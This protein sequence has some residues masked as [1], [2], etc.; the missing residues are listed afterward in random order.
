M[1]AGNVFV[2]GF[3]IASSFA[4]VI[5]ILVSVI[6]RATTSLRVV[7]VS[8]VRNVTTAP[9]LLVVD[10]LGTGRCGC[11]TFSMTITTRPAAVL[12][13]RAGHFGNHGRCTVSAISMAVSDHILRGQLL[14]RV[15]RWSGIIDFG[16]DRWTSAG[17]LLDWSRRRCSLAARLGD[18]IEFGV[19]RKGQRWNS[20]DHDDCGIDHGLGWGLFVLLITVVGPWCRLLA[21][22]LQ[23]LIARLMH[24]DQLMM[25]WGL[26]ELVDAVVLLMRMESIVIMPAG[27]AFLIFGGYRFLGL[28][29]LI[30]RLS[31]TLGAAAQVFRHPMP[32]LAGSM[33]AIVAL[34]RRELAVLV[35]AFVIALAGE[36][37]F[38]RFVTSLASTEVAGHLPMSASIDRID[39]D[40]MPLLTTGPG[41]S[42]RVRWLLRGATDF[43]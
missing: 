20:A 8:V 28:A 7:D 36:T 29:T 15:W 14:V 9:R 30:R 11:G 34:V 17:R 18:A 32:L 26:G 40:A 22:L 13:V 24:F 33:I 21:A 10:R 43:G 16:L 31:K 38:R 35:S 3:V 12:P 41:S 23:L 4:S 1:F 19:G 42:V 5:Q 27:S 2:F 37:P 39:P 6:E 25:R